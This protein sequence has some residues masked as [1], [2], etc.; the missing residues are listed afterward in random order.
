MEDRLNG[1]RMLGRGCRMRSSHHHL[2]RRIM[3]TVVKRAFWSIML[4]IKLL[5]QCVRLG[6]H[7]CESR[8]HQFWEGLWA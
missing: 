8:V 1:P 4:V 3:E 7:Y 5:A 6:W 2:R